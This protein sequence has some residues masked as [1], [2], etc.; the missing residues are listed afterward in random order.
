MDHSLH[1]TVSTRYLSSSVLDRTIDYVPQIFLNTLYLIRNEF[2]TTNR[3]DK[4]IA[5]AA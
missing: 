1:K 2:V 3:D 5:A 4:A